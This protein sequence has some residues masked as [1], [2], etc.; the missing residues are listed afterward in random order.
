[1]QDNDDVQAKAPAQ[2]QLE[3]YKREDE[4]K[5]YHPSRK[6]ITQR[7][8]DY[9]SESKPYSRSLR[10]DHHINISQ[11]KTDWRKDPNLPPTYDSYGFSV[12]PMVL[13]K[14]F[15]KLGNAVRWPPKTMKPKSN[16]DSR[17]CCEFQADYGHRANDC[18]DLRKEIEALIKKG[19]LTKYMP[20]QKSNLVRNDRT[21]SGLPPPPPHHKVI[22]FIAG[23]FEM[24]GDTY[25][26]AKRR[27]RG[28][29]VQVSRADVSIDAGQVLQFDDSDMEHVRVPQHDSLVKSLPTGNC[30]IKRILV[31]NGIT[32][33][34]MMIDT[35]RQMDLT[36]AN[37]EKRF[38]T[39][40][41]FNGE[42]KRTIGEIHLPTYA[43]GIN[44]LQRFLVI[45]GVS[46]YN[47]IL[48]RAWIHDMKT[49][50]STLHQVVKFPTPWG[51][52]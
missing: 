41:G 49:V 4:E 17:L 51:V 14:E 7:Q 45:D 15:E 8:M 33:N 43:G 10:D 9:N 16:L 1:M 23:G 35:L 26:Q 13:V 11:G 46:T 25:S 19:Y 48:G 50:S 3:E 34:I 52:Q 37:I 29:G 21:T 39:L 28:N 5:Y 36:E 32:V 38:M 6:T 27:A 42:T 2:I 18:V 22:N 30:L 24:C 44:L 31:D 12:S 40:V 20:T 47:I